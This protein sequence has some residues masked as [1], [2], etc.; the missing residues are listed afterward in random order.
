[1]DSLV[2]RSKLIALSRLSHTLGLQQTRTNDAHFPF[3]VRT[4]ET[5]EPDFV[6][7]FQL[8]SNA[9]ESKPSCCFSRT[10]SNDLL[11]SLKPKMQHWILPKTLHLCLDKVRRRSTKSRPRFSPEFRW[12]FSVNILVLSPSHLLP[13]LRKLFLQVRNF[14]LLSDPSMIHLR[15]IPNR[16]PWGRELRIRRR[17]VVH[18]MQTWRCR[19]RFRR[20][21]QSRPVSLLLI[22]ISLLLSLSTDLQANSQSR[23]IGSRCSH[24]RVA[25]RRRAQL[26]LD[27]HRWR[28]SDEYL[29][30]V[31]SDD[32]SF[33]RRD[34]ND[35]GPRRNA[36]P[37]MRV[38]Q[39]HR[40][41]IS[42]C[43]S[44][45]VHRRHR[46][47]VRRFVS[48]K[49]RR[50]IRDVLGGMAIGIPGEIAGYWKAHK[51]Y[52]RLPWSALFKPAID[53]CNEGFAI[54]KALAFTILKSRDKLYAD[55]SMR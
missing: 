36:S 45:V 15:R 52:G 38:K 26:S 1:M 47:Q 27:G 55:K 33:S 40:V 22:S 42:A 12:E 11:N 31:S 32:N 2:R 39:R 53:M 28:I 10:V 4:K 48:M 25:V 50:C 5:L 20:S 3:N 23:W 14:R 6:T 7:L 24:R 19:I 54:K 9:W 21:V 17:V 34:G 46:S 51:Q 49:I 35:L 43:S 44:T 8:Q 41:L 13:V 16:S 37:S 18:E 29:W 30:C